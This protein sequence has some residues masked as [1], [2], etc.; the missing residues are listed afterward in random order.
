[1]PAKKPKRT[2]RRSPSKKKT[3]GDKS[4][5]A[6]TRFAQ[7]VEAR[8]EAAE[9]DAEGRLPLGATHVITG[10]RPD[11]TPQLKRQRFKLF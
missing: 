2:L 3:A 8:G 6:A 1:M 9:R 5:Q 7:D 11:G 4:A 10:R